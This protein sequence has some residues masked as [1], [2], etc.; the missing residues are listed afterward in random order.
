MRVD[1]RTGE[2]S[3]PRIP[4]VVSKSDSDHW[5]GYYGH[6]TLGLT[7]SGTVC[8]SRSLGHYPILRKG[9][10]KGDGVATPGRLK[11]HP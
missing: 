7:P 1:Q 11:V 3:K 5:S 9:S 10:P 4:R 2:G 8:R 6:R